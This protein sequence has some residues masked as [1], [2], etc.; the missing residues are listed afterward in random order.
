MGETRKISE[1][2]RCN[3]KSTKVLGP[4][5]ANVLR[6]N[7]NYNFQVILKYKKDD[8]LYKAL[9]KILKI[10]EGNS[11]IKVEFDFNPVNL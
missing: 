5:M 7:N 4:S 1:Y 9:E 8:N 2:L 3:L 11:K 6:I 10:Y